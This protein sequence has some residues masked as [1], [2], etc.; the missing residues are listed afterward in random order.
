[1]SSTRQIS[2]SHFLITS[3]QFLPFSSNPSKSP[4]FLHKPH[5]SL[6]SS[7]KH[8]VV[9]D[10]VQLPYLSHF[11][12]LHSIQND[13]FFTFSHLTHHLIPHKYWLQ[14][15]SLKFY[16]HFD[17]NQTF[18]TPL[19]CKFLFSNHSHKLLFFPL[20]LYHI[21]KTQKF[22]FVPMSDD[23]T[24]LI[25]KTG[26]HQ[27]RTYF[28]SKTLINTEEND[29]YSSTLLLSYPK[30]TSNLLRSLGEAG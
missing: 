5:F 1:M 15:T 19:F 25:V 27:F 26:C 10:V 16:Y 24:F 21:L 11:L 29:D 6:T 28:A 18:C 7:K 23:L 22:I 4:L 9:S 14:T 12:Q 3:Y 2:P 17:Q 20:F 13:R 8:C 30:Q